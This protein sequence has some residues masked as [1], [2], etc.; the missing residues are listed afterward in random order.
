VSY[1][2]EFLKKI[3]QL[4]LIREDDALAE[5]FF[6][7]MLTE[8]DFIQGV[9][10]YKLEQLPLNSMLSLQ[11]FQG[12]SDLSRELFKNSDFQKNL[13]EF[14]QRYLQQHAELEDRVINIAGHTLLIKKSS[15]E[16]T[17]IYFLVF[18]L[19]AIDSVEPQN[20]LIA[21]TLQYDSNELHQLD[22]IRYLSDI[23]SNQQTMITLNDKDSL[24]GLYNRKSFD[25]SMLHLHESNEHRHRRSKDNKNS[26]YLA[27]LDIDHFKKINDT[28]G[29]L[30]GDEVLLL[31]AQQMQLT[32]REDDLLFRYGGEEFVV[33]L[34]DVSHD[35]AETV[36]H[37]FR[38]Y[39]ESYN[40]PQVDQ[41]TVS[42][43]MTQ[44]D[45][46]RMQ[47]EI[48]SRADQALY[49]VKEHGRNNVGYYEELLQNG[50]LQEVVAKD[51]IELF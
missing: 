45:I 5:A 9:A 20:E 18:L 13:S 38:H 40:F 33:I 43:G 15:R 37:R 49:Y 51:D 48:V 25:R 23:Y 19:P 47:S 27:L 21:N 17:A 46:E 14:L 32:F 1:T 2:A 50:C 36:L 44:L 28:Y 31:F 22:T 3:S 35:I 39:I 34:K 12:R 30:Y 41:V 26:A 24:T 42:I 10:R 29:H 16:K 11:A 8:F 6:E 7:F 4:T